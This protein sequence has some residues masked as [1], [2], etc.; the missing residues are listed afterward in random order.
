VTVGAQTFV[1]CGTERAFLK[2]AKAPTEVPNILHDS[3][4]SPA[5]RFMIHFDATASNPDSVTTQ[6]FAEQ[7][8]RLADS[9]Y[10][11][12]I[13]VLGYT[14]PPMSSEDHYDILLTPKPF[15]AYGAT[16]PLAD[17]DLGRSPSGLG[18]TK[19]YVIAD[20]RFTDAIYATK[21]Y[22]A[23][24]ITIFHEFFHV[25][26]FASYGHASTNT[27]FQ[28]MSSVWMEMVSSPGVL[29]WLTPGALGTGA[30][31][32]TLDLSWYQSPTGGYG[33]GIYLKYLDTLYGRGIVRDIWSYLSET[34]P[35]PLTAVDAVLRQHGSN[36]CKAY[37][38]FG[39]EAFQSGRRFTTHTLLPNASALPTDSLPVVQLDS[40]IT[41]FTA[42][43]SS[44]KFFV[45]GFGADTCAIVLSRS[46]DRSIVS[47]D[48]RMPI[49]GQSVLN[50]SDASSIC[51]TTFC[52]APPALIATVSP[53]P[54]GPAYPGPV[55]FVANRGAAKPASVLL[56]VFTITMVPLAH[57][58]KSAEPYGATYRIAWDARD[59]AGRDLPS[60]EYIY[61]LTVDGK[62]SVGKFV[63]VR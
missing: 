13:G 6:Q 4:R 49:E 15:G 54:V 17:G 35:N 41:N 42:L 48:V 31:F 51:D 46:T 18:R 7:A 24:R 50:V 16:V 59:D 14:A 5:G 21:G 27:Y 37:L 55:Y 26:Q 33:Q 11:F 63:I 22:D 9:A 23:L 47:G 2:G 39:V 30:Y 32:K 25:I 38:G 62:R 12:E 61:A 57:A 53:N 56:D 19:S 36:F 1:K 60:G 20:N 34:D 8:A 45:R 40:T 44:L 58:E 43:P 10:D 3:L 52:L 28:E 29:D